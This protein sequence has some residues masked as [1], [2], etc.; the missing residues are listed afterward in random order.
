VAVSSWWTGAQPDPSS[1]ESLNGGFQVA[2]AVGAVFAAAAAVI[3]G[4]Y[5]RPRPMA[6]P[7][8]EAGDEVAVSVH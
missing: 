1:L 6:V 8:A 3:G 5:L 2:F 7:D 4:A